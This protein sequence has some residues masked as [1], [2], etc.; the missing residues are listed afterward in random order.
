MA[1]RIDVAVPFF[2]GIPGV[3]KYTVFD[4]AGV[5]SLHDVIAANLPSLSSEIEQNF[6]EFS[7]GDIAL[8]ARNDDG[9]WDTIGF[10]S[11]TCN[12]IA[13][14]PVCLYVDIYED[15]ALV[16]QGDVDLKTISFNRKQRTVSFTCLGPLHRLE[17]WSA[18]VV[19]RTVPSFS[20]A[21][22]EIGRAH[23]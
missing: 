10:T 17:Q 13:R 21:G 3:V 22:A 14:F 11:A 7:T 5:G 20:D 23:V 16:F 4:S 15:N 6:T 12:P 19:R 18:E 2:T 9:G 8:T 1:L